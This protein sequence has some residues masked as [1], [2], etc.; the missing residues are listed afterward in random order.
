MTKSLVIGLFNGATYGL[1]A[2]GL[3]L[4][5]K[6]ARVFNFM[7]GEFGTVA[8]FTV[9]A[10]VANA[11]LPYGVAVLIGLVC[12]LLLGLIVERIIVRPLLDAPRITL[13]VA[14]VG[15]ALLTIATQIIV[16]KPEG[17]VLSPALGSKSFDILGAG[18]ATQQIL[19]PLVLGG[20]AVALAYFFSRTNQGLAVL[21]VSQDPLATRIVGISVPAMSRFIWGFAALLGGIAGILQAPINVFG[22]G[23]MTRSSLVPGFTAAVLGGMT[24]LP[25]AFLGGELVGVAQSLGIFYLGNNGVPGSAD[26]TVF[27]LLLLVLMVRP[28]GL[29]GKEA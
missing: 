10:L 1:L 16:A 27:A 23:F 8:A 6:G 9:W 22:P 11:G 21:A 13:L 2:V 29:L 4:V 7:Q 19:V 3:V 17:R 24:S 15:A 18:I 5:Y 26:L 14:T 28:Q 20:L 25:G 12:A